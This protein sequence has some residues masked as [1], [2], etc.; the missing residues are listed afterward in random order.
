[1]PK[2]EDGQKKL[3]TPFLPPKSSDVPCLCPW[4]LLPAPE[5][6][7]KVTPRADFHIDTVGERREDAPPQAY[8][9]TSVVVR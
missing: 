3:V 7:V 8:I 1:M 4:P 6:S 9:A 2:A 5:S